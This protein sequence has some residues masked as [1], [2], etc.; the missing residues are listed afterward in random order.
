M[1]DF[2]WIRWVAMAFLVW[3]ALTPALAVGASGAVLLGWTPAGDGPEAALRTQAA[4]QILPWLLVLGAYGAA[5][6]RLVRRQ[7]AFNAWLFGFG[8]MVV[9]A[10]LN[11]SM[12]DAGRYFRQWPDAIILESLIREA[13][14]G[15]IMFGA[16]MSATVLQRRRALKGA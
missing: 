6:V 7:A 5:A 4:W 11:S 14:A 9:M 8:L 2:W 16:D 12:D 15:L 1:G 10:L 3:A 13:P